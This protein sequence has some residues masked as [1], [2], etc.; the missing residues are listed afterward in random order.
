VEN[1]LIFLG[2]E[3]VRLDDFR[4]D[5]RHAPRLSAR[6][7]RRLGPHDIP[8]SEIGPR[9]LIDNGCNL[10]TISFSVVYVAHTGRGTFVSAIGQFWQTV[11][12]AQLKRI[13]LALLALALVP[14]T[15][16]LLLGQQ[17]GR[18]GSAGGSWQSPTSIFAA[19]SPGQRHDGL[20]FWVKQRLAGASPARVLGPIRERLLPGA[21]ARPL[22]RVPFEADA[23]FGLLG[24]PSG[25]G[26]PPSGEMLGF[27]PSIPAF[28]APGFDGLFDLPP[29]PSLSE[30]NETP[31]L[32][33]GAA[34]PE[35][36][37]WLQM[38]VAIAMV[39]LAMRRSR[40]V[41]SSATCNIRLVSQAG[42]WHTR[43]GYPEVELSQGPSSAPGSGRSGAA[44]LLAGWRSHGH[45]F[46]LAVRSHLAGDDEHGAPKR[47]RWNARTAAES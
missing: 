37:T 20:V 45:H 30:G 29:S 31:P 5:S 13:L 35:L 7:G 16:A 18:G 44:G 43:D 24:R 22:A 15:V 32:P 38:V 39:G 26:L 33:P 23:P 34:V 17:G 25:I 19:R 14:A 40:D 11:T 6:A 4:G 1:A 46:E 3:A 2:I 8:R 28:T 27:A 9:L 21:R 12:P 47:D 36:A 42:D 10:P 41:R